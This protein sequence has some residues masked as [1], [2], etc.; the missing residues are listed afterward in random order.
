[1]NWLAV[2]LGLSALGVAGALPSTLLQEQQGLTDLPLLTDVSSNGLRVS[3]SSEW[4]T[5]SLYSFKGY[6]VRMH[7]G[8]VG[9]LCDPTV[10]SFSGYFDVDDRHLFFWFFESRSSPASDPLLMWTNGGPGFSS[11]AG[12]LMELGPCLV[13]P[14]GNETIFNPYGWNNNANMIFIDHPANVGWSYA[15]GVKSIPKTSEEDAKDLYIFFQI[16]FKAI[17]ELQDLDF[18]IAGESYGGHYVPALAL[19]IMNQNNRIGDSDDDW[20]VTIQLKSVMIGNGITDTLVQFREVPNYAEQNGY[21]TP[22]FPPE[23]TSR[24]RRRY[25]MCSILLKACYFWPTS[26][27]CAPASYACE[28]AIESDIGELNPYDIRKTCDGPRPLCYDIID[29]VNGFMNTEYV[30]EALGAIPAKYVNISAEVASDFMSSGDIGHPS[31][32]YIKSLLEN[33]VKVLVY[34]GDAD[35]AC[36]WM[37]NLAWTKELKWSGQQGYNDSEDLIWESN[38]Q[39]VGT[40]RSYENLTFLRIFEAGHMVPL[41]QP[42]L[43]DEMVRIWLEG[44]PFA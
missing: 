30:K 32:L 27:L 41:D 6:Q 29:D 34:A 35:S 33:G 36:D 44:S 7:K 17:P 8:Q 18:H 21:V 43:S 10:A 40:V 1:M 20:L 2:L 38:G 13:A 12:L 26:F 42:E 31:H 23:V 25:K 16:L 24:M 19:E 3:H 11:T 37:G 9:E 22:L 5:F 28:W 39:K 4:S 15:D 14:G